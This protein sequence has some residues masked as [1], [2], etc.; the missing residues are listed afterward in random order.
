MKKE[1]TKPG[2][3]IIEIKTEDIIVCSDE[4]PEVPIE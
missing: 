4:T 2:I 1:Y 3:E